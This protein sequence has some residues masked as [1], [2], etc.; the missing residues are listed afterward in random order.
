MKSYAI[1]RGDAVRYICPCPWQLSRPDTR[2]APEINLYPWQE[3]LAV[4]LLG[5]RHVHYSWVPSVPG[6]LGAARGAWSCGAGVEQAPHRLAGDLGDHVIVAVDVQHLGAVQFGGR[7][8]DQ[9]RDR[10]PV[11]VADMGGEQPLDLQC[12][13][14]HPLVDRQPLQCPLAGEQ[15]FQICLVPRGVADFQGC[16]VARGYDVCGAQAQER[17]PRAFVSPGPLQR[18]LVR[19]QHT[20]PHPPSRHAPRSASSERSA[21]VSSRSSSMRA[22]A[23]W[24]ATRRRAAF[25][26]ATLLLVPSSSLASDK[27]SS[28][29]ST[30]VLD[31]RS[32]QDEVSV[33]IPIIYQGADKDG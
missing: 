13:V 19:E 17:G 21:P 10:A 22:A 1:R 6:S 26:V 28:S 8:D 14:H 29:R 31:I 16:H 32:S 12:A 9:V 3:A 2:T 11:A 33:T 20:Q 25:T 4:G 5:G 7:G 24:F 18:G 23:R 30:I 15:R 27:A